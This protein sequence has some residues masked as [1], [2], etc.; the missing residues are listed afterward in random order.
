MATV[1]KPPIL[2]GPVYVAG[3]KPTKADVIAVVEKAK[4][5][6]GP[7]AIA[8][9]GAVAGYVVP[10]LMDRFLPGLFE[11]PEDELET[12]ELEGDDG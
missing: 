8:L 1:D 9:M 11:G 7:I 10:K 4:P 2:E 12:I 5:A 3:A 6:M